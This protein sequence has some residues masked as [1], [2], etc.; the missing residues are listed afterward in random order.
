[1]KNIKDQENILLLQVDVIE[2]M[3]AV[4]PV[5]QPEGEFKFKKYNI[6]WSSSIKEPMRTMRGNQGGIGPYE[7]GVFNVVVDIYNI[8]NNIK[9]YSFDLNL[10]GYRKLQNS[11]EG[12]L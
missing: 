2:L 6:S 7:V 1:M 12:I 10:S 3:R 11:N 9:L 4:N 8:E 5:I